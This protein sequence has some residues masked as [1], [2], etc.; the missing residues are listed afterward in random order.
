[1]M[2]QG[3][4]LSVLCLAAAVVATQGQLSQPSFKWFTA[5]AGLVLPREL[6]FE[7]ASGRLG[8]LNADGPVATNGHPFFEALGPNGRAC[9]TCHQPANAMSLSVDLIR[10]RWSATKG[11]DPLFAAIDGSDNPSAPQD[12][13]SS[14]SLLLNRGLFRVGLPWPPAQNKSPEFS[15]EVVRDPTGVNRDQVWTEQIKRAMAPLRRVSRVMPSDAPL[16]RSVAGNNSAN[17]AASG[18]MYAN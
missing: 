18:P 12:R 11:K 1:M 14:H 16:Y 8:I 13:D 3:A 17:T 6:T 7:N 15:I 10:E 9:V 5:G 4:V 2:K